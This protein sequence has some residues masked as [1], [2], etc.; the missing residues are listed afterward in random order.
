VPKMA[1][2]REKSVKG[3]DRRKRKAIDLATKVAIIKQ[4][5]DDDDISECRDR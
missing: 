4:R 2:K 1:S 3:V 5:V